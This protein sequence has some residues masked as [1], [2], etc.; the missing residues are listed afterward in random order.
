MQ[1]KDY[2]AFRRLLVAIRVRGWRRFTRADDHDQVIALGL[3]PWHCWPSWAYR[4]AP[5]D[6]EPPHSM[7]AKT[8][9]TAYRMRLRLEK[10]AKG[11]S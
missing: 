11:K 2:A 8:W 4:E 3:P 6:D 7:F 5:A 9:R 1:I 10:L